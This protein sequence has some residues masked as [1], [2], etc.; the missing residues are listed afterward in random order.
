[1]SGT[2]SPISMIKLQMSAAE[3]RRAR[4]IALR[5]TRLPIG[6]LAAFLV[7]ILCRDS[8]LAKTARRGPRALAVIE[9][10]GRSSALADKAQLT[11]AIARARL[12]PVTVL[13]D[14]VY[15]DGTLYQASPVP[16]MLQ[17]GTIYDVQRSGESLGTFEV[18]DPAKL[19]DDWIATGTW[20]PDSPAAA[21][22]GTS[23]PAK[24][25][26]AASMEKDDQRPTL[27]RSPGSK[28]S[29][30]QN[31]PNAGASSTA[32]SSDVYAAP[33]EPKRL[34]PQAPD[35]DRPTLRRGKPAS[36]SD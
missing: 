22:S 10:P 25:T 18:K 2:L 5:H 23:G 35:P 8:A 16:V 36:G 17:P 20:K 19:H 26:V 1:M 12:F 9:V 3:S 34:P 13:Q 29:S 15:F 30:S 24:T 4:R 14:D 11:A 28:T 27:R 21:A 6:I 31:P 32:A 33:P 7:I